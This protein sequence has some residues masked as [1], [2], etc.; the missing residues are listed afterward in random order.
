MVLVFFSRLKDCACPLIK[1]IKSATILFPFIDLPLLEERKIKLDLIDLNTTK[2]DIE[3]L[4]E[5]IQRIEQE[6]EM[7]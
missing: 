7:E 2:S 5:I 4:Q 6:F 3:L 1:T